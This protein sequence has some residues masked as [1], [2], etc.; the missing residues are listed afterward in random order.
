[1]R[2]AAGDAR[3]A[4]RHARAETQRAG[5]ALLV[6]ISGA[7]LSRLSRTR[8]EC[9]ASA[10]YRWPCV[11]RGLVRHGMFGLVACMGWGCGSTVL[12]LG[13]EQGWRPLR[14]LAAGV[15]VRGGRSSGHLPSRSAAACFVVVGVGERSRSRSARSAACQS[16]SRRCRERAWSR[17]PI[18]NRRAG[19][20]FAS[21][22]KQFPREG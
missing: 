14:S 8:I 17:P 6:G 20:P 7:P 3:E 12:V 16:A 13:R 1:M 10:G 5:D 19:Y 22:S 11:C 21:P 9:V 4:P 15:R 18:K 2:R